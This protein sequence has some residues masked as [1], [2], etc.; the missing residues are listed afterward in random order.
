MKGARK[1]MKII[2]MVFQK[3][4]IIFGQMGHFGSETDVTS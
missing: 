1:Y 3:K 4:N 2:L